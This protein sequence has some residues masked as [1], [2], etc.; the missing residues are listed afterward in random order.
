MTK[1]RDEVQEIH[2]MPTN[3]II[4]HTE[5][6]YCECVPKWDEENKRDFLSGKSDKM[7]IVHNMVREKLN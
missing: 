5:S 3:D 2:T 4:E 6:M 1:Q 7:V